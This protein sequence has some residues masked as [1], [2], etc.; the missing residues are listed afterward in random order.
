MNIKRKLIDLSY[1]KSM[2]GDSKELINEMIGIFISQIPEFISQM[3]S[4]YEDKDWKNL[5]LIAHKAKSSVAIM[6]MED[7]SVLLKELELECKNENTDNSNYKEYI[8]KFERDCDIA[9]QELEKVIKS[10]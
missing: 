3:K 1:L 4:Y 8:D 6:G 5:G 10:K 2:A 7:Q 9:L